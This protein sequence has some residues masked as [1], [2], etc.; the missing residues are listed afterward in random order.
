MKN[1]TW[2]ILAALV[3]VLA[4]P[5]S[6]AAAQRHRTEESA[7]TPMYAS[8]HQKGNDR[9]IADLKK[10]NGDVGL[11]LIGDSITAPWPTKGPQ[12]YPTFLPWRWGGWRK[13]G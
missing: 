7:V 11:L 10:R 13:G 5:A 4:R 3:S 2:S 1:R 6:L 8:W 9:I 12:S